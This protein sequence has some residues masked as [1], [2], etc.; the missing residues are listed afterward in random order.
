MNDIYVFLIIYII[1]LSSTYLK[2][3]I[4]N[5]F[6]F[7][8]SRKANI[9]VLSSAAKPVSKRNAPLWRHENAI[10]S[11]WKSNWNPKTN[12]RKRKR[13]RKSEYPIVVCMFR[14]ILL[15]AHSFS[16]QVRDTTHTPAYAFSSCI[17]LNNCY[18]SYADCCNAHKSRSP[19]SP[20]TTKHSKFYV[21]INCSEVNH[22]PI[23]TILILSSRQ[24]FF[25]YRKDILY[26][27]VEL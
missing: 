25:L 17:N 5:R 4:W 10:G 8:Q 6:I 1:R 26:G 14:V 23:Q 24:I 2:F 9:V 3:A 7:R 12:E 11:R 27:F 20:R 22:I 18:K 19:S 13:V 15:I 21:D 16:R